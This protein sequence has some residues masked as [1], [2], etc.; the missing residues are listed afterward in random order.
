MEAK[1]VQST[2]QLV[3]MRQEMAQQ[4]AARSRPSQRRCKP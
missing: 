1:T 2:R 4:Y 3:E